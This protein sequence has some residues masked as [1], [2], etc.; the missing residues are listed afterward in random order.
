MPT[1]HRNL[2]TVLL[3]GTPDYK[4]ARAV[5]EEGLTNDPENVEVYATLDGVLSALEA[6]PADR[7]TALRRFRTP[8]RMPSRSSSSWRSPSQRRVMRGRRAALPRPILPSKK[9]VRRAVGVCADPS[10]FGPRAADKRIAQPR[11]SCDRL[12]PNAA[13]FRSPRN[14]RRRCN[15]RP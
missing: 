12:P 3:L 11:W 2:G 15:P 10:R 8:E 4:E 5:L 13:T 6:P 9:V 14:A 1:L 7:V